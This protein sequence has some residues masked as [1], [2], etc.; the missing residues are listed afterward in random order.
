[1]G[2]LAHGRFRDLN[3]APVHA[4]VG[5]LLEN[6]SGDGGFHG[7]GTFIVTESL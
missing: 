5:G 6:F 2:E 3:T 7:L 1:M 4:G